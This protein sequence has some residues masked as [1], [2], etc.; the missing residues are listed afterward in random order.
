MKVTS[1]VLG[2]IGGIMSLLVSIMLLIL[3]RM[4]PVNLPAAEIFPWPIVTV[5]ISIGG[6]VAVCLNGKMKKM[7]AWFIVGSGTANLFIIPWGI[8]LGSILF[9]LGLVLSAILLIISGILRV[10]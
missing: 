4:V 8:L 9:V 6:I 10:F 2:L 5:L 7:E 1:F 3:S